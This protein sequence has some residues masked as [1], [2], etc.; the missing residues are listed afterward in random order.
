[1]TVDTATF[2]GNNWQGN[3]NGKTLLVFKDAGTVCL[4]KT[5]SGRQF[6]P[7]VL[8]PFASVV[9]HDDVGFV[10]GTII[11]KSVRSPNW[12]SAMESSQNQLH[13]DLYK[14]SI[15]CKPHV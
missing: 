12:K 13:G 3:D 2:R 5:S 11:A 14:G 15:D 7:T 10:D 6:G 1:M 8:A 9:I 4:T